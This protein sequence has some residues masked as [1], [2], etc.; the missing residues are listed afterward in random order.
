MTFKLVVDYV[1]KDIDIGIDGEMVIHSTPFYIKYELLLKDSYLGLDSDNEF[2]K[3]DDNK[4][5]TEKHTS[6]L[7]LK[8]IDGLVSELKGVFK[9]EVRKGQVYLQDKPLTE[10]LK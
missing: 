9:L 2:V 5:I 4:K 10:Y 7:S 3:T 1:P 8:N 6:K